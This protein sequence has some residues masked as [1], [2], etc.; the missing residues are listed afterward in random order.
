MNNNSTNPNANNN[1]NTNTN[2]NQNN[3]TA[4]HQS[5]HRHYHLDDTPQASSSASP[6]PGPPDDSDVDDLGGRVSRKMTHARRL[7]HESLEEAESYIDNK[8]ELL[9]REK[10]SIEQE[11]RALAEERA[12]MTDIIQRQDNIIE[13]NVGGRTFTTSLETLSADPHS[14]L[15]AMFSGR[16]ALKQDKKSRYFLDRDPKHFETILNFLRTSTLAGP[17]SQRDLAEMKLEAEFYGLDTLLRQIQL[18]MQGIHPVEE[19]DNAAV[20]QWT[21]HNFSRLS[22]KIES[23]I[24]NVGEHKWYLRFFPSGDKDAEG[25]TSF[26]LIY[27]GPQ[28][29]CKASFTL[30]MLNH[31]NTTRSHTFDGGTDLFKLNNGWGKIKFFEVCKLNEGNGYLSE[32]TVI[33]EVS[34]HLAS[35]SSSSNTSPAALATRPL[36]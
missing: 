24:F 22:G 17:L 6:S 29:S 1:N 12:R 2:I 25:H 36:I 32:D 20:F 8:M 30:K 5:H 34:I 13:L 28:P 27:A 35:E 10:E 9:R 3:A 15:A 16:Y 18:Q 33:L 7:L 11:R 21:L 31:R 19:H 14:M 23:D 4:N 26:Y